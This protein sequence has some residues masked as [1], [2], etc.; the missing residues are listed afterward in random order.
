MI[1]MILGS[2]SG[3]KEDINFELQKYLS[4]YTSGIISKN[5]AIV[6]QLAKE[7]PN[8]KFGDSLD[9]KL[10]EIIPETEFSAH[11]NDA[12]TIIIEAKNGFK[13]STD[14]RVRLKF[15]KVLATNV[16]KKDKDGIF[17][18]QFGT[19][20]QNLKFKDKSLKAIG[21]DSNV[22][23]GEFNATEKFADDLIEKMLSVSHN[24][25]KDLKVVWTHSADGLTHQ[26]NIK[27]IKRELDDS[28]LKI[29][30][31]VDFD[32]SDISGN[33]DVMIPGTQTFKI[34]ATK[35]L[36]GEYKKIKVV[37]S[38]PLDEKQD[39]TGLIL[40]NV[41]LESILIDGNELN[42]FTLH[43]PKKLFELK[44]LK[45]IKNIESSK[46]KADYVKRI[47]FNTLKPT[48]K[49]LGSDKKTIMPNNGKILFPFSAVN[50]DAVDLKIIQIFK[51]NIHQFF[52]YNSFNTKSNLHAVG[53]IVSHE[54]ID[55][56]SLK[57][58][59]LDLENNFALDLSKF[60]KERESAAIYRVV[61]SIPPTASLYQCGDVTAGELLKNDTVKYY[62]AN[63]YNQDKPYEGMEYYSDDDPCKKSY[64]ISRYNE[65]SSYVSKNIFSSNFGI[66]AKKGSDDFL[67]VALSNVNSLK[68]ESGVKIK[69]YDYQKQ[70]IDS[71]ITDSDGMA[72]LKTNKE[73]FLLMVN[74]QKE[75][76]YL[77]LTNDGLQNI[78]MFDVD[79]ENKKEGVSAYLYGERGVWRPGDSLYLTLALEDKYQKFPPDQPA[80][81]ELYDPRGN[82]VDRAVKNFAVGNLYSFHTKTNS[83]A[84]T[85]NYKV[86]VK[87]GPMTFA[88]YV[89]I[90]T[91]KPNHLKME[92]DLD[93]DYLVE[94]NNKLKLSASWLHGLD[95][96]NLKY[97]FKLNLFAIKTKFK[98]YEGYIFDD[99]V[100]TNFSYNTISKNGNLDAKGNAE[101]VV[102]INNA[103]NA[104]GVLNANIM[105]RVFEKSGDYS[106]NVFIK[107]MHNYNEYVGIKIPKGSGWR[108]ALSSNEKYQ[109]PIVTVDLN[110]KA[111][112]K[113]NIKVEVFDIRWNWWWS[114]NNSENLYDY[115]QN[116][117][118][119]KIETGYVNT[120]NGKGYY[121]LKFKKDTWGRKLIRVTDTVSHHSTGAVFYVTYPSWLSES[122][123]QSEGSEMLVFNT[124]KEDYNVNEKVKVN[125]PISKKGKALVSIENGSKILKEF[126]VNC[127][128]GENSF[129]FMTN[130]TMVPN[131]YINVT[132][133]QPYE[134]S[135][136]DL[137]IR[138][139]GIKNINV[140][141]PKTRIYPQIEMPKV[142]E[143]EKNVTI[144]VSEKN[145]K[146][147]SFTLAVV[148]EGLLDL[149]AFKTPNLWNE[150][151]KKEALGVLTWDSYKYLAG[152]HSAEFAGLLAVGGGE[153]GGKD[154]DK[155]ANRFK[156]VVRF[157]GPFELAANSSKTIK[158]KMPNYVGSV[159]T[160]VVASQNG[161]YGSVEKI[162]PVKKPLMVLATMPRVLTPGD[163]IKLPVNL[164]VMDKNVKDVKIKV[165]SNEFL[166]IKGTSE[167]LVK[168]KKPGERMEYFDLEVNSKIGIA[169]IKVEVESKLAKGIDRAYHEI[170][171]DVRMPNP[172]I[173]KIQKMMIKA[174]D[175]FEYPI[176]H[177]GLAGTNNS[178]LEVSSFPDLNLDKRL[179]FLIEYPH[180]CIE[181]TTSTAF[182]Q[183]FLKTLI[184]LSPEKE[185][186]IDDNLRAAMISFTKFQTNSGGFGY[187]PGNR[188]AC[189]WGTNY[190]GHFLL[191]AKKLGYAIPHNM[192]KNWIS[193]QSK[194]A[195]N[196]NNKRSQQQ[197]QAYRLYT[198]A[199]AKE[200]ALGAMN[201]LR[202]SADLSATSTWTLAAAYNLIGKKKVALKMIENLS[203][204]LEGQ[205]YE[206]DYYDYSYGSELRDRAMILEAL[207]IL[208]KAEAEVVFKSIAK[209]VSEDSWMST[210]TTAYALLGIFKY[211]EF[212]G[213]SKNEGLAFDYEL[214][215]KKERVKSSKFIFKKN[216]T[217]DKNLN[218]KF[219]L[220]QKLKITNNS[221]STI[222]TSVA[223]RAK[224]SV[225]DVVFKEQKNIKC[226]VSYYSLDGVKLNP[227]KIKQGY[228]FYAKVSVSNP[229][230]SGEYENLAI[231]Q[232]FP[233]GWEIRNL[234]KAEKKRIVSDS[235]FDYQDIRDDRVY[236]YFSLSPNK[237]KNFYVLLN[238]SYLGDYYL[239]MLNVEAMYDNGISATLSGRWVQVISAID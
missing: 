107:K 235:K 7:L 183:L 160:M 44:I 1:L 223:I 105:T 81:F 119:Y 108:E 76:G 210:Q 123:N 67:H 191:E 211:L 162:T 94:D 128:Q 214:D 178:N 171:I 98:K 137:P 127:K 196:W 111:V 48:I 57:S 145:N 64:Y 89:K 236:T 138:M 203:Y 6:I 34:I 193:Y 70:I 122:Q 197:M 220:N 147:M 172:V 86:K 165:T 218:T 153:D 39:L 90:E 54:R 83:D 198:L 25:S 85:G 93:N 184:D 102:K 40:A 2:C 77:K 3:S 112:S 55:L 109:I 232:V 114:R 215:G 15:S 150:F 133:I 61:L 20:R 91:I 30:W 129:E 42:L 35:I 201:R 9:S 41:E 190:A 59:D 82:L 131:A 69:L 140:E 19:I 227:A 66:I 163:K 29:N 50:T 202:E 79:G 168:I 103:S 74:R 237:T 209:V 100:K 229:G 176:E 78:S 38:D 49:L 177:F 36:D 115:V 143:P 96:S 228:D 192:L 173:T 226:S 179:N 152:A 92:L 121:E 136:N 37:F 135:F 58:V 23:I 113:K 231:S 52:Q 185:K 132:Y 120:T 65:N 213:L 151:Y 84:L 45:E 189:E 207:S 144:K 175:S 12:S 75:Y 106:T 73:G 125:L 117:S 180:G 233:S 68:A 21:L 158:F 170:E 146:K 139:F 212:N 199:L 14:Y 156:P 141:D 10:I 11:W 148:D 166:N 32:G 200:P 224:P 26:F 43:K 56:R 87:I 154:V 230:Y 4:S 134:K 130:S 206:N 187:W 142:L 31:Q 124:D 51:N 149:T 161:A 195:N 104:P 182:P 174:G 27:G 110:G 169:K 46:L 22:Y 80:V 95:A 204:D 28:K 97:D 17:E 72:I 53:K 208:G 188:E 71:A 101:I 63:D 155:K 5:E 219:K 225:G 88:D 239:P 99:P 205:E 164:F 238:A 60:I 8:V 13:S 181:Q 118:K 157:F 18:F 33:Y 216:L 24:N 217:S 194:E 62:K 234:P 222:Y 47:V 221:K 126:W 186:E 116:E 16:S 167:R 159:K